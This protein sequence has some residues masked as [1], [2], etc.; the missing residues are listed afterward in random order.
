MVITHDLA[1]AR[2]V[3]DRIAFLSAGC[4]RFV[5]DWAAADSSADRELA[6]FLAGRE[7][8]ETSEEPSNGKQP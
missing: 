6:D 3:G 1:L 8:E 7:R 4:F 2:H 5:G